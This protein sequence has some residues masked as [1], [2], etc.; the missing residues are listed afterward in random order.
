MIPCP[1]SMSKRKLPW[2]Q[3]RVYLQRGLGVALVALALNAYAHCEDDFKTIQQGQLLS[4]GKLASVERWP[5][6]PFDYLIQLFG[7]ARS[8][9]QNTKPISPRKCGRSV[10]PM[11]TV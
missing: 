7:S 4:R 9:T 1:E 2:S 5:M 6:A 8:W 11:P 10:R 3:A